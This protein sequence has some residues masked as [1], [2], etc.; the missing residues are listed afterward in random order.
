MKAKRNEKRMHW[1]SGGGS[2]PVEE[3]ASRHFADCGRVASDWTRL[4]CEARVIARHEPLLGRQVTDLVLRHMSFADALAA[5]V[6]SKLGDD[7]L[8]AAVLARLAADAIAAEPA[9]AEAALVDL[10]AVRERDPAAG[11]LITPFLR[12]K[13]YQGLQSYR[14]AH[15]LWRQGR[16]ELALHLQSLAGER[17]AIDIHPAARIGRGIMIDHGH[18]VVIGET[19]VVDD[20]VSML[21][22]VTLGGTGKQRGD[23]HPKVR[24]GVLLGAG[25]KVLGNI[26]IGEGA[27]V[28]AGSVVLQDVP[29]HCTVAG[30]PARVVSRCSGDPARGMDHSL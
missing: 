29:V 30:V 12:F 27:K 13:G 26:V 23:R 9:I 1:K 25:A 20:D 16:M 11:R 3:S 2:A 22:G 17:F 10:R 24:S 21:H 19:A 18:G 15:W 8:P 4:R 28:G 7:N 6:G 14:V 5:L